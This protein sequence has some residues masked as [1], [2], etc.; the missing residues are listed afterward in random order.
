MDNIARLE[1]LVTLTKKPKVR[2]RL[3]LLLTPVDI[4]SLVQV[5][6]FGLRLTDEEKKIYMQWWRQIFYDIKIVE[7]NL[8][9]IIGQ[10]FSLLKH[11]L[12]TWRYLGR[13]ELLI[14]AKETTPTSNN[15][16]QTAL[17]R[18]V[19]TSYM[20]GLDKNDL[21][22][23]IHTPPTIIIFYNNDI[24]VRIERPT[25]FLFMDE[26]AE[27]SGLHTCFI[28]LRCHGKFY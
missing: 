4:V 20:C 19:S 26:P 9:Y 11:S 10:G 2:S 17:I 7:D 5:T 22:S 14:L 13:T 24:F 25:V 16:L 6:G 8:V 12:K 1:Q 28:D 3:L 23:R 15:R 18:S 21:Q 27:N